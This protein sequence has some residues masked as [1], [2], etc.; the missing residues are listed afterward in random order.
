MNKVLWLFLFCP[1]ILQP[2]AFVRMQ[3]DKEQIEILYRQMCQVM[4]EKD[5]VTLDCIH[6]DEF[7]LTH[8]TG[9]HQT[10]KEYLTAI[11]DGTLNYYKVD[12]EFVEAKIK[13]DQATL[14]GRSRVLAAV[15]GGGRYTWKLQL[16]FHLVRLDGNWLLTDAKASTY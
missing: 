12:H 15:F 7:V 6:A 14:V 5:I 4:I 8:M 13:D 11:A 9:M 10:K 16:V 2:I 1:F 3:N